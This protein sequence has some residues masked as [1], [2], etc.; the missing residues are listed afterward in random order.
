MHR[1]HE[2]V[3]YDGSAWGR[4]KGR[5]SLAG[6]RR[7]RLTW[8]AV[9]TES[10][11]FCSLV[12]RRGSNAGV[13]AKNPLFYAFGVCLIFF[14]FDYIYIYIHFKAQLHIVTQ[15]VAFTT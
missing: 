9:S 7:R 14:Y 10:N 5:T 6:S 3:L 8:T 1:L 12:E 4:G 11:L 15:V 2:R 13:G